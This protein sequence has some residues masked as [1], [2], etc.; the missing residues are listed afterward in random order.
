MFMNNLKTFLLLF[1]FA[2][3]ISACGEGTDN[4]EDTDDSLDTDKELVDGEDVEG[5][6]KGAPVI[7]LWSAVSI[8]KTPEAKKGSYL[9]TIHLGEK[10]SYLGETVTDST[11]KGKARDYI[12]VKLTDGTTGWIEGRFMAIDAEPYALKGNSKLYK[13]PDIL[14]AGKN[15]FEKMQYVVV[16]EEQGDWAKVKGIKKSAGWYREGWVKKEHLTGDE[17]DVTVA[18]LMARALGKG[19]K[20]KKLEALNE[21]LENSDLSSSIFSSDIRDLVDELNEPVAEEAVEESYE[22]EYGK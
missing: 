15:E 7:C 5:I 17:I 4:D 2:F 8:R 12:K 9:T 10:A 14:S 22:E 13:R 18:V 1:I 16:L 19:D 11:G 20:D 21:I 6:S 3:F